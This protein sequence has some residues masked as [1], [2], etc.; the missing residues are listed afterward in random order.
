MNK[1][2]PNADSQAILQEDKDFCEELVSHEK[3]QHHGAQ[4]LNFYF[5]PRRFSKKN[6]NKVLLQIKNFFE[7][8]VADYLSFSFG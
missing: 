5:Q 1:G 2:E 4:T 6:N 8:L 3:H 7:D